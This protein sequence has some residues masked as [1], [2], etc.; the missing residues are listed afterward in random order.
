M[1]KLNIA[2]GASS[3]AKK[4][5]NSFVSFD[6]LCNRL[7]ETIRT[8]ETVAE[9]T[10]AKKEERDK[11]KDRGGFVGGLLKNNR[12][13]KENIISRSMLTLDAD[14]AEV[15]FIL[16]FKEGCKYKTCL[17]TTHGHIPSKP[18]IRIIIPL[19][20]DVSPDE[21]VAISRYFANEW[22]MDQ[23]DECSYIPTQLMYWPTTPKDGEFL[24][25]ELGDEWLNPDK[26]LEKYPD[27]DDVTTLPTSSK[28]MALRESSKNKQQNPLTKEGL[29]GSFCRTYTITS[30]IETFLSDIYKASS[31]DGRYDYIPADSVAGVVIYDDLFAYSHHATDP[32]NGMLLN[33]F[34]LVRIHKFGN[35][36][37]KRSFNEMCD[38]VINDDKVKV[39]MVDEKIKS[40]DEDFSSDWKKR[41]TY[42]KRST[43]LE[44]TSQNLILILENDSDFQGF[45]YNAL[46]QQIEIIGEVPWNRA[47]GNNFWRDSDTAQLKALIDKRYLAF[48]NRNYDIAFTKVVDDRHFHPIRDYLNNLP[49]WDG[50]KRVES[51]FIDNLE[52]DD[53]DYVRAVTRKIFAAAVARIHEPGIKFDSIPVI[54]GEQGIGKSTLIKDL[55]SSKY[56]SET[57]SLTDMDDKSGAEK[58]QGF[59][60]IEIGELAGM[61]KADIEKVK[62][63]IS[64]SDD[65]FRPSYG[66]VVASHPRQCI[67]IA[68]INGERGYLRDI[69]GNRR[70]WIIKVHQK[71]QKKKW[72]FTQ[73]FIN[74]FWAEAQELYKSGEKLYLEGELL[75]IAKAKQQDAMEIDERRGVVEAYLNTLL[76][77]NWDE[78]DL[79]ERRNFL[80]YDDELIKK[81]KG[82]VLRNTVSNLEIWCECLGKNISDLKASDSYAIA[83][84][85]TQIL[86]WE[87]TSKSKILHIYGKQRYYR[88]LNKEQNEQEL[89]FN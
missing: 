11:A 58:L 72:R 19:S 88:R 44:N 32:A 65:K 89:P 39:L 48:S 49:K 81:S 23:F 59:W 62:A 12:R 30:A 22:Q 9:Y 66:K 26:F 20:R 1:R 29:V 64:T 40:I 5:N 41:L 3:K 54:D 31:K 57:L 70:F 4:W 45:A 86:E 52:A 27:W 37:E 17:Y 71:E 63:F 21:Y 8:D 14:R 82:T 76:P 13:T 53:N 78:L 56:Y 74:Q 34:D 51:L 80:Y 10:K 38:F 36:D 16:N 69:T 75:S 6:E 25:Y 79:Q 77:E 73:D 61:K 43:I 15:D 68:T 33:A 50:I 87:R 42:N 46:A 28:E 83:A 18:R 60:V 24:F 7:K 55:V 84:I 85:M 2:I 67:I 35:E 47:L